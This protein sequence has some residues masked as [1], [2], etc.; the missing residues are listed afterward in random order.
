MTVLREFQRLEATGIWRPSPEDQRRDVI[1]SLGD[2]TLTV[3]D[4]KDRP[5]AHWSLAAVERANPG[6]FPAIFHPDGDPGET[7]EIAEDEVTMLAAIDTVQHAIE[8]ARPHPGRLRLVGVLVALACVIALLVFALPQVMRAQAL[9]VVSDVHRK[10]IGQALLGRIERV[11]GQACSSPEAN[12][13]LKKLAARTDVRRVAVMRAGVS[14]SLMLPGGIVLLNR[15]LVE[16]FEDP[17]VAAG[18]LL[19]ERARAQFHDPMADLLDIGGL[20]AT[21]RLLTTGEIRRDTLDRYAAVMLATPR[22]PVP[23]DPLLAEFA[24]AAVPSTPYAYARDASGETTL[25]LI[26]ADPM[27]GRELAPVLNDRDWV[28]L[29]NICG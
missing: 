28:Q 27:A 20:G 15:S 10:A 26:E 7:L 14:E 17:A 12:P 5:L 16:D 18:A 2:A 4:M 25:G 9:S 8:R 6:V 13:I 24:R 11:S 23:E 22:P 19:V 3:T 29:Q 1:I 21:F